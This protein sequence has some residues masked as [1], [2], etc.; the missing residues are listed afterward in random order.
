MEKDLVDVNFANNN[1]L[2]PL[3]ILA[4]F[5]PKSSDTNLL[6]ILLNRGALQNIP[7]S[8]GVIP[9]HYCAATGKVAWCDKLLRDNPSDI[10]RPDKNRNTPLHYAAR[11]TQNEVVSL[12][13]EKGAN[14]MVKGKDGCTPL[15]L[16]YQAREARNTQTNAVTL[17]YVDQNQQPIILY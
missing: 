9:L 1:G 17:N 14:T 4:K 3:H 15:D 11:Y 2:T 12:L 6:R 7:D 10:N 16:V 5:V 8:D 13:I